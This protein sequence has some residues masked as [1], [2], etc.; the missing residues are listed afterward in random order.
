MSLYSD[1][2]INHDA[3]KQWVKTLTTDNLQYINI[4]G[5][6]FPVTKETKGI[7]DL[8]IKG[9]SMAV[10]NLSPEDDWRNLQGILSRF[11]YNAFFRVNNNAIRIANYYECLVTPSNIKTYKKIIQGFDY[12]DIGA[13]HI[14]D[15]KEPIATIGQKSDLIWSVFYDYFIDEDM[16]GG[17][18][19]TTFNHEEYMAI[20]LWHTENLTI[21]EINILVNE[22]LLRIS[23]EHDL[24]FSI[25]ELDATMK[26]KGT[27][28][29][30]GIQFHGVEYEHIPVLY[31]NN[32]FHSKDSRLSF[33]SF[34][35]VLEYFFV[36]TQNYNFLSLFQENNFMSNSID[37]KLLRSTLQKYKNTLSERE[38]LKLVLKRSINVL[39]LKDWLN[40]C[41][42]Y[43]DNY[44]NNTDISIDLSKN[45]DKIISKLSDRIYYFRCSI[46]HAKGDM[47]EF[48]AIPSISN[49]EISKELDLMKYISYEVLKK[50]SEF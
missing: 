35:Q 38:S 17:I 36:R 24:D 11:F 42:L 47:D 46:A 31:L 18:S 28:K 12:Q 15:G 21:D 29:I 3:L 20:Q 13:I 26:D 33:L 16:H 1:R 44:C 39:E 2:M 8:Q 41:P 25:V 34:Y 9:F 7:L 50:C 30:Y 49:S 14:Y 48:I 22:I 19:H 4:G 6:I 37:H 23:I 40:S 45:D 32:T 27:S 5:T 10:Q 43:I